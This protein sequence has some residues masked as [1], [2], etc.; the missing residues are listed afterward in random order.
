MKEDNFRILGPV[1]RV[2]KN[3]KKVEEAFKGTAE[4][5][6]EIKEAAW[7]REFRQARPKCP[8][9]RKR[10]YRTHERAEQARLDHDDPSRLRVYLCECTAY[11]L[12]SQTLLGIHQHPEH[13]WR[14]MKRQDGLVILQGVKRFGAGRTALKFTDEALVRSLANFMLESLDKVQDES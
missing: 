9:P 5:I 4:A 8:L 1:P 2:I 7:E 6:T 13:D 11:H 12:T 14:L 10:L 3:R